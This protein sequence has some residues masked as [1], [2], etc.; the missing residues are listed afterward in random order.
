MDFI[1]TGDEWK[2]KNP[3]QVTMFIGNRVSVL[4]RE[5]IEQLQRDISLRRMS[6]E[7]P[8]I[9]NFFNQ[10]SEIGNV[11]F[12]FDGRALKCRLAEVKEVPDIRAII[13]PKEP[14]ST[15]SILYF[16]IEESKALW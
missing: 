7:D 2:N 13:L 9:R 15:G 4:D 16:R 8:K 3:E 14:I 11:V 5:Q 1:S 10:R 12:V 6:A